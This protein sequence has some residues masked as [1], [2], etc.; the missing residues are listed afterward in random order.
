ME[1]LSE[2]DWQ[3]FMDQFPDAHAF[4]RHRELVGEFNKLA[5]WEKAFSLSKWE[6]KRLDGLREIYGPEGPT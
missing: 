6:Q 3:E 4:L 2:Q 5:R 1:H